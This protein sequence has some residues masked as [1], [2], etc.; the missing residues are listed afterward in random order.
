MLI[1]FKKDKLENLQEIKEET[2]VR[3]TKAIAV[4]DQHEQNANKNWKWDD[5]ALTTVKLYF[6]PKINNQPSPSIERP[7]PWF[8]AGNPINNSDKDYRSEL[9]WVLY[10]KDFGTPNRPAQTPFF[11]LYN[12]YSGVLRFFVYNYRTQDLNEGSKTYYIGKLSYTDPDKHNGTLS[13]WLPL[14]NLLLIRKIKI[15][16]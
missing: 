15:H 3:K 1:V 14:N 12:R 10:L 13:F 8:I 2:T 9:G 4:T 16:R 7:L 6:K 11:A 5:P